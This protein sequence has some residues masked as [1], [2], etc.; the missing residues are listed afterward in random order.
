MRRIK[1]RLASAAGVLLGG[2]CSEAHADDWTGLYFG[3]GGGYGM[4]NHEINFSNG[5]LAPPPPAFNVNLDGLGGEGGMFTL[6]VG[7]DYQIN[8]RVLVGAFF[9][10]DWMDVNTEITASLSGFGDSARASAEFGV[11]D[12]WSIGGRIGYLPNAR[13][14]LFFS[15]GYTQVD[16]SDLTFNASATGLG[17][18]NGVIASVGTLSGTFV[19]GGTEI[20]LTEAISIKGEYRYTNLDPEEVTLLPG[21]ASGLDS[22]VSTE[23]DPTIQTAR[24]TLNYR[25]GLGHSP[26]EPVVEAS[27]DEG[28]PESWT[29]LYLGM[30]G[31]YGIANH[32]LDFKNGPLAPPPP[33]FNVNLD[34]LGGEGGLVTLGVGADYQIT[35]RFLVGAFFDHDWMD[36]NTEITASLSGFGDSARASAGFEV[37][38]Q[39]SLGGRI[40]YLAAPST[41]LFVSAG[42]TQ[43]DVS[44]LTFTASVP[45]LGSST[46]VIASVGDL[47]GTF[48]G[49]GAEIKLTD[50]ISIKGEYRYTDLDPEEVM[51]LPGLASGI[52][53]FVSTE[54]DPTIQTARVSLNYR[55]NWDRSVAEPLK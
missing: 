25:F 38:R 40:G 20:K 51:L 26:S 7:A 14:L 47:S 27:A 45:G 35:R 30:G 6:G 12:Q 13:T 3:V 32:E 18:I 31:G 36:V 9:D 23:L 44:D 28:K 4:A 16:V 43:V 46:G 39:W 29:G 37:E 41:L 33:A 24:V 50:A 21:L 49:G 48:L 15:A 2:L 19:G 8:R 53:S 42:Y 1:R 52:D 55:F 17:S 22:F 5:P 34:G 54:L 11:E 10:H